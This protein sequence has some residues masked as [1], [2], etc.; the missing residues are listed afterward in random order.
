M[1]TD[2]TD[3]NGASRP[4]ACESLNSANTW[5]YDAASGI[6]LFGGALAESANKVD[7]TA[8]IPKSDP[9]LFS[10]AHLLH[11][12][13]TPGFVLLEMPILGGMGC[14]YKAW[15]V[16]LKRPV[17][18]KLPR[19]DK[20]GESIAKTNTD[21]DAQLL[22]EASLLAR[23][24]HPSIASCYGCGRFGQHSYVEMQWIEGVSLDKLVQFVHKNGL[25]KGLGENQLLPWMIAL[26]EGLIFSQLRGVYHLDLKPQN[27]MLTPLSS[28]LAAQDFFELTH[29]KD[30]TLPSIEEL[31]RWCQSQSIK[32]LDFGL[33]KRST[34]STVSNTLSGTPGYIAPEQI[35]NDHWIPKW[36][37]MYCCGGILY[38]CMTGEA[39]N[40][41]SSKALREAFES[42]DLSKYCLRKNANEINP[43]ASRNLQAIASKC[44]AD[45]PQNRYAT[46]DQLRADLLAISSHLPLIARPFTFTETLSKY[47]RRHPYAVTIMT[48]L[49]IG[50]GIM[51][52]LTSWLFRAYQ[53]AEIARISDRKTFQ[54]AV[55]AVTTFDEKFLNDSQLNKP[56]NRALAISFK[57]TVFNLYQLFNQR[58]QLD[59]DDRS[60]FAEISSRLAS[61]QMERGDYGLAVDFYNA[62]KEQYERLAAIPTGTK[63]ASERLL[64]SR[65]DLNAAKLRLRGD[66][67]PDADLIEE[68]KVIR[69]TANEVAN[70]ELRLIAWANFCSTK[71]S[72]YDRN[73]ARS[74][75]GDLDHTL[76]LAQIFNARTRPQQQI[77]AK[78]LHQLGLVGYKGGWKHFKTCFEE[79]IRIYE[80]LLDSEENVDWTLTTGYAELIND[81]GMALLPKLRPVAEKMSE[82]DKASEEYQSLLAEYLSIESKIESD[83][84]RALKLIDKTLEV[85]PLNNS[86]LRSRIS[87]HWNLADYYWNKITGRESIEFETHE[88]YRRLCIEDT[89]Q[90]L[91][92]Q[93]LYEAALQFRTLQYARLASAQFLNRDLEQCKVS[94][95]FLFATKDWEQLRRFESVDMI[96]IAFVIGS[97]VEAD[98]GFP[99]CTGSQYSKLLDKTIETT[100]AQ[101]RKIGSST[102]VSNLPEFDPVILKTIGPDFADCYEKVIQ[103]K[104]KLLI[105]RESR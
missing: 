21:F 55:E 42:K 43:A 89:K 87:C 15:N 79:A 19:N 27:I 32:I 41:S 76:E 70:P 82:V 66:R 5:S 91:Q 68:A 40:R 102:V 1:L 105:S 81:H 100:E 33:A 11:S 16:Q 92:Q 88:R 99:P 49:A 57:A 46:M 35:L 54:L 44:L 63:G 77:K 30:G 56:E 53:D 75:H 67:F 38:A 104:S 85:D 3:K 23:I 51:G 14:V 26:I 28:E 52:I 8:E 29:G 37:D 50:L 18:L 10:E 65:I 47:V 4:C 13:P 96:S 90:I 25:Q 59:I 78:S 58:D 72:L 6:S 80:E 45:L 12:V 62:T 73:G 64:L 95:S 48:I 101:N 24:E 60:R 103:L 84:L 94:L 20:S 17:A 74:I 39:P 97:L 22:N 2:P 98:N 93:P 31:Q 34:R 83:Y 7:Y 86:V 61:D 71:F 9:Q 36:V 69:K